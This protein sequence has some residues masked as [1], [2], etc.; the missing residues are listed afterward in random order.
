MSEARASSHVN[1][2]PVNLSEKI[3]DRS[4]DYACPNEACWR[5][6]QTAVRPPMTEC[7]TCGV[8]IVWGQHQACL[9][10]DERPSG[11]CWTHQRLWLNR[12]LLSATD[13]TNLRVATN[14]VI[15][16]HPNTQGGNALTIADHGVTK[17]TC[18]D[19]RWY[20]RGEL[21]VVPQIH[22]IDS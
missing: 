18:D 12:Q 14:G 5:A 4:G 15:T 22:G 19:V 17:M 13:G 8:R 11:L 7:P 9:C 1:A 10:E 21:I 20:A 3:R 2:I 6:H 16:H